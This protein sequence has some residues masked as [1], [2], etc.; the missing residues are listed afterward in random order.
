MVIRKFLN[1]EKSFNAKDKGIWTF[2]VL[3]KS[4]KSAIKKAVESLFSVT[5]KNVNTSRLHEKFR[6]LKT[7][8]STRRSRLK[9]ARVTLTKGSKTLDLT[10]LNR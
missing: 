1:T 7:G 6:K 10:K 9:I 4:N 3:P 8:I 2:A 5:V